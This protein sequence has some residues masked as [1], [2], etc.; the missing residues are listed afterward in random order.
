MSGLPPHI[1]FLAAI[2]AFAALSSA[3]LRSLYG[4]CTLK[5]LARGDAAVI[6]GGVMNEL[7]IVVSGRLTGLE[8]G[9][10]DY[11]PGAAIEP[12]AFFRRQPPK[13]TAIALRE[14]VLLTLAWEDFLDA[15]HGERGLLDALLAQLW[16]DD[17]PRPE[18]Q[19]ISR[20]ALAPAGSLKC[21]D[22]AI[23]EAVLAG[24]E[25]EG[26]I[27]LLSRQSFGGGLPGA[28]ALDT[29]DTAQWL[30]DLE[31][32]FDLTVSVA[33]DEDPDFARESIAESDAVLFV[34][35][36]GDSGLSEL[37]NFAIE[38][39]G[40]RN[41]R[42]LIVKGSG[43][44]VK[45]PAEWARVRPGQTI[46]LADLSDGIALKVF[47]LG[48]LGKGRG[49]AATSRGVY[50]AAI[51]GTLQALEAAGQPAV[52]LAAAGSAIFPAGLIACGA[53]PAFVEAM[54]RELANPLF[55]KRAYRIETSLL[56]PGLLDNFLAGA[57][58]GYSVATAIRPFAAIS[59][60]LSGG[61][62]V[63]HRSG[64]LYVPVRAGLAPAGIFPPL[65]LDGGDILVSGEN[66]EGAILSGARPPV[67]APWLF[68]H[69]AP[70]ALGASPMP[71]K[72]LASLS[73]FRLF[74]IE[75]PPA[76]PPNLRLET[77]IGTA[78]GAPG[79]AGIPSLAIPIPEGVGA[80]DWH[81]WERVR[82]TAFAYVSKELETAEDASARG[83]VL[84][85]EA[86]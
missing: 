36:G 26:E 27:R 60:S 9:S 64:P 49:V 48:L 57:L 43:S 71:Y 58:R 66:E 40:A 78:G 5:V 86:S 25:N 72:T 10:P 54:F 65:I 42:L 18:P 74:K 77:M 1:R 12:G 24:L 33:G 70:P 76:T 75:T 55:W 59:K 53:K 61:N 82:D 30:Q 37:E 2:P 45:D 56:D 47:S 20:L 46:Q 73:R 8:P 34:A 22:P 41:C 3:H 17:A 7:S 28:I 6:P 44:A 32:E 68:L 83:D 13:F 80:M 23:R 39:R 85:G 63:I 31:L 38:K 50:A 4:A 62:A 15:M 16:R 11:G 35:S 52:S 84:S 67:G 14:T 69:I 21:L 51:F 29:P 81:E 79:P 19:K